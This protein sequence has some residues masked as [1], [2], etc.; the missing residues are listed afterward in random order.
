[1]V[2]SYE[3]NI[4][5]CI[6]RAFLAEADAGKEVLGALLCGF[7]EVAFHCGSLILTVV[8]HNIK[9]AQNQGHLASRLVAM[10]V[11]SIE[12]DIIASHLGL[13]ASLATGLYLDQNI[14]RVAIDGSPLH[15]VSMWT[16]QLIIEVLS[17]CIVVVVLL[18]LLPIS[19][20]RSR[21]KAESICAKVMLS[22]LVAAWIIFPGLHCMVKVESLSCA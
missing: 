1:M 14:L 17:N 19:I 4:A 22:S 5:Y 13:H 18:K 7:L 20:Q 9:I 21:E 12:S 16:W 10:K 15:I 2:F 8:Y 11:L 3:A 6:R